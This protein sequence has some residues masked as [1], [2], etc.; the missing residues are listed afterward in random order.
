LNARPPAERTPTNALE[1]M[2]LVESLA[3][4]SRKHGV[5]LSSPEKRAIVLYHRLIRAVIAGQQIEEIKKALER[6][7]RLGITP[8]DVA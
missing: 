8:V 7:V 4:T 6:A 5:Y 1:F 3:K 2:A